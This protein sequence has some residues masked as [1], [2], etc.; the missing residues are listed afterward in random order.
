M[1]QSEIRIPN[2]ILKA[3]DSEKAA[4]PDSRPRWFAVFIRRL[5]ILSLVDE[6]HMDKIRSIVIK[7]QKFSDRT[8]QLLYNDWRCDFRVYEEILDAMNSFGYR[9]GGREKTS[10]LQK[11]PRGCERRYTNT[12]RAYYMDHVQKRTQWKPPV[13]E[14]PTRILDWPTPRL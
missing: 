6:E 13:Q 1:G 10:F 11:M 8:K 4:P 2:K 12:G 14:E 7:T 3:K 9:N 5:Y